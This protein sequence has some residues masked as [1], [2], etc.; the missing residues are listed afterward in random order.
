[1]QLVAYGAQ[2]VYLTGNPQI[3]FF[4]VVYRRHTN[5]STEAI[6]QTLN[7]TVGNGNRVS[8]TVARNGDLVGR[9]YYQVEAGAIGND[10]C[11]NPG[12]AM[13]DNVVLEIGGQQVDKHYGH[14]MEACAEL[15]EKNDSGKSATQGVGAANEAVG[16]PYQ[17]TSM[18]G[19]VLGAATASDVAHFVPL[20]FSFCRNPRLAL[21]LIALQYHEVKIITTFN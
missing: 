7:G 16:T 15:T 1:M 19:G 18:A 14:W 13:I 21:P 20:Q 9:M 17:L 4:K 5:F 6:E 10:A 12:T 11:A 3:T 8:A 2:D